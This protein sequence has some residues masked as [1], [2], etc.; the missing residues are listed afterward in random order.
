MSDS[1]AV[2]PLDFSTFI[3][4]L[5][6]TAMVHLGKVS[7]P[8]SE[9]ESVDLPGAKQIID[10]ISIL[11]EKTQGNLSESEE[12][13]MNSLLYDLRISYVDAQKAPQA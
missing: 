5:G 7:S 9:I 11:Q 3:L 10:I 8:G 4:S 6:S 1:E 2:K 13:L 12:K